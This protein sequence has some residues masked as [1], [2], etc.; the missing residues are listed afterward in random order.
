MKKFCEDAIVTLK[1]S[2]DWARDFVE[3]RMRFHRLHGDSLI[4]S[5]VH[6]PDFFKNVL[7]CLAG[8]KWEERGL[9]GD[10]FRKLIKNELTK[11]GNLI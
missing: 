4:T 6:G 7:D 2:N 10:N 11:S 3:L 1:E 8:A 9:Y 5:I